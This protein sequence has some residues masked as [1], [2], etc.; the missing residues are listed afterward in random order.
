MKLSYRDYRAACDEAYRVNMSNPTVYWNADD[1][2]Y[3]SPSSDLIPNED[4][5]VGLASYSAN[6]GDRS[7]RGT[8][9]EYQPI[10]AGIRKF[11]A[12][13][14]NERNGNLLDYI[15]YAEAEAAWGREGV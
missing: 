7:L 10:A 1:G 2:F 6:T 8:R 5:C 12:V 11:F 14:E 3:V 9:R 15:E 4:F 13:P